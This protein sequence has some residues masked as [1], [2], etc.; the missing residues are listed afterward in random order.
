MGLWICLLMSLA[1]IEKH[2]SVG[3]RG[4]KSDIVLVREPWIPVGRFQGEVAVLPQAPQQLPR[5]LPVF[6]IDLDYPILLRKREQQVSVCAAIRESVCVKP[7][8]R[9]G[10]QEQRRAPPAADGTT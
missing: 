9:C 6:V 8:V 3:P 4:L 2:E 1:I 5:T 7:I 10:G